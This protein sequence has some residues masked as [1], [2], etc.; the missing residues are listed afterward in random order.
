MVVD[1]APA[2]YAKNDKET[3]MASCAVVL[4]KNVQESY[5]ADR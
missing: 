2:A 1:E 4:T 3:Y 5:R